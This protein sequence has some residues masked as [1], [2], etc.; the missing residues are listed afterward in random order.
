VRDSFA[1][2]RRQR[3][4]T[5]NDTELTLQQTLEPINDTYVIDCQFDKD[6]LLLE[7]KAHMTM[8]LPSV[9]ST[10]QVKQTVSASQRSNSSLQVVG[11]KRWTDNTVHVVA[12]PHTAA[13]VLQPT[14]PRSTVSGSLSDSA[15][16]QV[17]KI[18]I[19]IFIYFILFYF[20]LFYFILFV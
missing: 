17:R 19:F 11:P 18:F 15:V 9:P 13:S 6:G 10:Q 2:A 4:N 3:S 12:Q 14:S 20:I 1:G 8:L 7:N 5:H 16:N